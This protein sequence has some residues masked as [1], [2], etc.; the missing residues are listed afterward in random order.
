MKMKMKMK[1]EAEPANANAN[2]EVKVKSP[3][4]FPSLN[5]LSKRRTNH[6]WTDGPHGTAARPRAGTKRAPTPPPPRKRPGARRSD[7][8]SP[9]GEAAAG[10]AEGPVPAT[11]DAGGCPPSCGQESWSV[12][13]PFARRDAVPSQPC[14]PPL[15]DFHHS[16]FHLI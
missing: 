13:P 9:G 12:S 8:A 16:H 15:S 3:Q 14:P 10:G 1:L 6:Q 7:R 4:F 2:A 5:D 11:E